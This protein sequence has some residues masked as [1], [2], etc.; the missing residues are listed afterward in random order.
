MMS[1]S[2]LGLVAGRWGRLPSAS[3]LAASRRP[4]H[5]L[6]ILL[7]VV[8]PGPSLTTAARLEDLCWARFELLNCGEGAARLR[9]IAPA[10]APQPQH[11]RMQMQVGRHLEPACPAPCTVEGRVLG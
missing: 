1:V 6:C 3:L 2:V 11:L 8:V 10:C 7:T 4:E 9:R 5:W